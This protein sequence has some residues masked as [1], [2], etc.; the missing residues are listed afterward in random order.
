[1]ATTFFFVSRP[2]VISMTNFGTRRARRSATHLVISPR[3]RVAR[4]GLPT[5][6]RRPRPRARPVC[7]SRSSRVAAMSAI[8]FAIEADARLSTGSIA[9]R[10]ISSMDSLGGLA[11]VPPRTRN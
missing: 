10:R 2:L 9:S 11:M 6:P 5:A 7:N 4:P 1:L 3:G 8:T